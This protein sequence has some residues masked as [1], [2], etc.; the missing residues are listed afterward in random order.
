M[1]LDLFQRWSQRKEVSSELCLVH[2]CKPRKVLTPFLTL[3]SLTVLFW[4]QFYGIFPFSEVTHQDKRRGGGT[5]LLP[6]YPS[7]HI[8]LTIQGL[9]SQEE[10]TLVTPRKGIWQTLHGQILHLILLMLL[11]VPKKTKHLFYPQAP[12]NFLL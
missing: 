4:K 8:T 5:P 11:F 2:F 12:S 6:G 7:S 10:K 1:G 3:D 9:S